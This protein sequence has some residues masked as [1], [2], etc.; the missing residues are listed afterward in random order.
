[1]WATYIA[2]QAK[3]IIIIQ[4]SVWLSLPTECDF[5]ML[6]LGFIKEISLGNFMRKGTDN[7][8]NP[9]SLRTL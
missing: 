3:N 8:N 5:P 6:F 1:M 2:W 4:L 9:V 7:C